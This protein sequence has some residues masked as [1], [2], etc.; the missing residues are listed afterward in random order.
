MKVVKI[1]LGVLGALGIGLVGLILACHFNP[2][3][4]D[5]IAEKLYKNKKPEPVMSVEQAGAATDA[6]TDIGA[7]M[8]EE[9]REIPASEVA[10]ENTDDVVMTPVELKSLEDY[11][12]T[13]EDVIDNVD[14][15]FEDCFKQLSKAKGEDTSFYNVVRDSRVAED[16]L[17]SYDDES[18]R[19]GFMNQFMDDYKIA[20]CGWSVD[21]E[22]LQAGYVLVTHSYEKGDEA[23]EDAQE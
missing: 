16:V 2:G 18:Y 3:L 14:D 22:E 10:P 19:A 1:M 20:S 5:S 13:Q 12:L 8:P 7:D 11:G 23:S 15:Y 17:R 6:V 21:Q 4:S 9:N